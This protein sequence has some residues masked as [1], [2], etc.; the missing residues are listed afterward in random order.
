[1][2]GCA[3][4]H[5]IKQSARFPSTEPSYSQRALGISDVLVGGNHGHRYLPLSEERLN[6]GKQTI[7]CHVT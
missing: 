4:F 6:S 7:K 3:L 1:M 5:Y 2:E